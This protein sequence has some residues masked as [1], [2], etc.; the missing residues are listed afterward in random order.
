MEARRISTDYSE[1]FRLALRVRHP[2]MDPAELSRAFAIEPEYSFRA[3]SV[4]PSRSGTTTASV[5]SESYWLGELKA[6]EPPLGP[7]F[8]GDQRL[9]ERQLEAAR[10][11]LTWTL[12]LTCIRVLKTH[13]DLLRRIRSDG[14]E[15]TLLVTIFG[16][17]VG[18]FSLLPEAS[19]VFGDLGVGLEFEL[20]GQ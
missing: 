14:G 15:I 6:T 10:K 13:A 11:S 8:V 20:A 7:P 3:G 12:S 16:S 18:S 19:K 9:A 17:E 5:R 4:R 1:A 2:S